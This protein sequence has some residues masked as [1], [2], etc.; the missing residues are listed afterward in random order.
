M[1]QQFIPDYPKLLN[2]VHHALANW[3]EL[4]G[5]SDQ[6]LLSYLL[7][8]RSKRTEYGGNPSL[9]DLKKATN[10]VLLDAIEE[11]AEQEDIE[12][13]VLRYR[14][15]DG[16]IIRQVAGRL[17]ASSDQVN[18]WQRAAIEDLAQIILQQ[19][20]ALREEK[21]GQ[22]G[23]QLPP[24]P[25][26]RLFGFDSLVE[27][28][29]NQ[30]LASDNGWLVAIVGLGGIGKTSLA[31]AI[32]RNLIPSFLYEDIVWIRVS[33]RTL[34]GSS[35]PSEQSYEEFQTS[36]DEALWP[37]SP[38][39]IKADRKERLKQS[40][41]SKP[42]L[43]VVD[44][45]ETAEVMSQFL[46]RLRDFIDPSKFLLT[47]RARPTI[48]KPA[49]FISV[50]ELSLQDTAALVYHQAATLGLNHLAAADLGIVEEIYRYTGGN[51]LA[52][53]LVVSLS[54]VLPLDQILNDLAISRPGPIEDLYRHIY[55]ESWRQ[56]SA[57]GRQL[58]QAMPLVSEIGA[59]PEQMKSIS[60][61]EDDR[62]WGAVTELV[63]RSLLEVRGTLQ[64][65][66]YGIHR[67]TE[68]FLRT[69]IIHWPEG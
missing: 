26:S 55:W 67:L 25:Y 11:L 46:E 8:V 28:A 66:R 34:S 16:E 12:A 33:N 5:G 10:A 38:A 1:N 36:L 62:F 30:L 59:T 64:D 31:D 57:Q 21:R 19:E 60:E 54:A 32:V 39:S 65:R 14:F 15:L 47:S 13:K 18:R 68:T 3:A 45:L 69:E 6:E 27:E 29:T 61:L 22:L 40:L 9:L 48:S 41:R 2:D 52:V 63:S 53:K 20:I 51:P 37:E 42:H 4:G 56:L 43:I 49:Y 50:E 44:N 35:L 23:S 7:L 58:L 17:H 24:A